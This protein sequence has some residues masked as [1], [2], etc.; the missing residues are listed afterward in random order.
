[1]NTQQQH[2]MSNEQ[3]YLDLM[4]EVYQDGEQRSKAPVAA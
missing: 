3:K 4:H 2:T 1:M